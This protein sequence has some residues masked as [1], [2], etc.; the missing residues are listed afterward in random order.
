MLAAGRRF[1]RSADGKDNWGDLENHVQKATKAD[2]EK[3]IINSGPIFASDDRWFKGK[4]DSGS[5]R[6]Q[7]PGRYWKIVLIKG[8]DGP[9]AYGFILKQD[10]T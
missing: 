5:V 4:D 7:I 1:N 3:A 2:H 10:V 9:E 6:V 8:A